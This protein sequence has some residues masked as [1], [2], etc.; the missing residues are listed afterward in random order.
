MGSPIATLILAHGAGAGQHSSFM[1]RI[2]RAL[3]GE[4]VAVA[5]FDFPYMAARRKVPDRAPVLERAWR[6][7][8]DAVRADTAPPPLP[9]FIGG[10]SMGGR[11]ASHVAAQGVAGVA[12]LVFLGY[13][14]HPPGRPQQRR[15]AHLP[16][17]SE[18]MLFVQ[19]ERDEFGTVEEIRELLPRLNDRTVVHAVTGG[20]HSFK[21]PARMGMS[22]DAVLQDIV[23]A[24]VRFVG[25]TVSAGPSADPR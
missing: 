20:D 22:A 5:T 21:V 13:P 6:E 2:A 17:I 12:G 25:A 8:I 4:R 24:V 19:G 23:G 11:M 14:L 10:K 3:A 18:P 16:A 7:A 15:D 1:V 9:L